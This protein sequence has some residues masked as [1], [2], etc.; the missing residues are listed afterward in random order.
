VLAVEFQAFSDYL[1]ACLSPD[2]KEPA[3]EVRMLFIHRGTAAWLRA[4]AVSDRA[5]VVLEVFAAG[6]S[7]HWEPDGDQHLI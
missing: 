3:A 1:S 4:E 7:A 6:M 2:L 5:A